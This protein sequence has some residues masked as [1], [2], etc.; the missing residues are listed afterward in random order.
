MKAR[1]RD[2][3]TS[4]ENHKR[5]ILGKG[6][7]GNSLTTYVENVLYEEGVKY[8]LLSISEL[9]NKGYKIVINKDCCTI[10]NPISNEIKFVGN[11]IGNTYMLNVDCATSSNLAYLNSSDDLS[12]L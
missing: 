1:K 12:W 5:K 11:R 8:N 3:L 9:C 10:S 2:F 6:K 4:W 7:I